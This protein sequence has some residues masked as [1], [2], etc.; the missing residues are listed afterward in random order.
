MVAVKKGDE[1]MRFNPAP[2]DRL[3]SGD[4]LIVLGAGEKLD[5][6]ARLAAG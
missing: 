6:I 4:R 2:E 5:E 1:R 3:E